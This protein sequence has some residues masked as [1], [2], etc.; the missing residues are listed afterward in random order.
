MALLSSLESQLGLQKTN[1]YP[2][3]ARWNP[4]LSGVMDMRIDTEGRWWHEGSQIKRDALVRL[5]SS[6]L[7]YESGHYFLVTPVEK[8]QIEVDDRPLLVVLTMRNNDGGIE[9]VTQVG[10]RF[11]LDSTHPLKVSELNGVR[12]PEVLV[13]DGLWA[14]LSRNAFYDLVEMASL[15]EEGHCVVVSA[16]SRFSL[17]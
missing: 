17:R 16:G 4:A 8:W 12:I 5:F 13:R 2:P 6:I 3:V 9:M 15:D 11:M 7:K 1:Q 10:D 14:R